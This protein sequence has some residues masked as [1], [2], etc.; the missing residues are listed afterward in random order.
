MDQPTILHLITLLLATIAVAVQLTNGDD[1][2]TCYECSDDPNDSSLPWYDP[3]CAKY[4]YNGLTYNYKN[5]DGCL[6]RI[7]DSGYVYRGAYNG[8][9]EDGDCGPWSYYNEC[10]C[11][12]S[13]CNT[14]SYCEQCGFSP[15]T[16]RTTEHTTETT[17]DSLTTIDT[18]PA[19][20]TEPASP[21]TT[22]SDPATT[23]R[24]YHCIDCG[25]VDEDTTPIIE[26]N[27]LS[28]STIMILESVEVIR[29]GSYAA[30][31]DGECVEHTESLSCWC[32]GDLCNKHTI[33]A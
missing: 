3:Q 18:S 16:P 5:Y 13:Y 21:T 22:S 9:Y 1:V 20:T 26:D 17:T 8:P 31:P 15:P 30:H 2:V 4:D 27:F 14:D 28:C 23:L 24:C 7:Y 12:G 29:G 6:L 11:Q 25:T 32:N 19:T 10:Y 33:A